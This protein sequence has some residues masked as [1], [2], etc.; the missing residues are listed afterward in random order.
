M[1]RHT[2]EVAILGTGMTDMGRRDLE[3]E[4]MTDQ[5]PM[6]APQSIIV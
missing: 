6:F 5:Y 4:T 1:S 2:A 3:L